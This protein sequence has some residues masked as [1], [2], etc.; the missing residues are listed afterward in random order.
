VIKTESGWKH[1]DEELLKMKLANTGEKN[2]NWGKP[3]PEH[4]K[5]I[6]RQKFSGRFF[7]A[8][9]KKKIS[10]AKKKENWMRGRFGKLHPQWTGKRSIRK[11]IMETP[12]YKHWRK[13]VLE[14]DHYTCVWCGHSGSNL[15]VDHI[16][17]L[18]FYPELI[19]DVDNGRVLCKPCH[20]KTVSY[21]KTFGLWNKYRKPDYG[22]K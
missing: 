4:V 7:S 9:T 13:T 5:E 8:E 21:L 11:S 1:T 22:K 6:L 19:H 15:H 10:D 20:M 2:H 18:A 17:P 3:S 12:E 14:R 16:K